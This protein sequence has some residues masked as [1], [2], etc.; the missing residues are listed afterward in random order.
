[1]TIDQKKL[2]Q[3]LGRFPT[4]VCVIT[5]IDESGQSIGMTA[6]SFSSVSLD[7][8]LV[9]W[10]IQKNSDCFDAFDRNQRYA[11]NILAD[12]QQA[13]SNAYATK[14][15]HDLKDGDYRIGKTGNPVLK[16]AIASFEC[17]ITDRHEGGDHIILVAEVLCFDERPTGKP[18]LFHA[19]KYSELK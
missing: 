8:A 1:M 7:P 11:V 14:N 10:S 19:G 4:G 2:R 9:L 12:D 18:L 3:A 13:M 17:Q 5:T 6:N 15:N 16:N